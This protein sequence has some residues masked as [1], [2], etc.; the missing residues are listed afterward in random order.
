MTLLTALSLTVLSALVFAGC[1]DLTA[2]GSDSRQ[3]AGV[4]R[5]AR[6]V[7]ASQTE[8]A[9][10]AAGCFWG[11]E[12]AFRQVEG[13]VATTVGYTGG[14][15]ENPTYELVCAGNTGHSEAVQI[16]YDPSRVTYEELLEVFWKVH[17]PTGRAKTQYRSAIFY[18]TP[19]QEAVAQKSKQKLSEQIGGE[20]LTA[21]L[22]AQEF[23]P[24]EEYHQQ[25]LEKSRR[26]R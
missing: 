15:A 6:R 21:I 24:A 3:P 12:E 7:D 1:G 14:T 22:P 10:F 9:T 23:Y 20:V 16:E 13:V 5:S 18:H 8:T 4:A 11:V 19:T 25:Y 26:F 17:D 2:R